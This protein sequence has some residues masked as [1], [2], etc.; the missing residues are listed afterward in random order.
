VKNQLLFVENTYFTCL[1]L[2]KQ[3]LIPLIEHQ[4]KVHI[5]S[6]GSHLDRE[7]LEK[8]GCVCHEIPHLQANPITLFRYV[9][10]L[11][12]LSKSLNP[13][14]VLSFTIRPNVACSLIGSWTKIPTITNTAGIGPLFESNILM[15]RLIRKFLLRSYNANRHNFFENIDDRNLFLNIGIDELKTSILPGGGVD[16]DYFYPI[17]YQDKKPFV[18][19]FITRII[20][21]KGV[22]EFIEGIKLFKNKYPKV[23]VKFQLMG[24]FWDKALSSNQ[25]SETQVQNWIE[26]GLIEYLG[27]QYDIRPYLAEADSLILPSYREGCSNVIMQSLSMQIPVI[28]SNVTGCNQLVSHEEHGY[29]FQARDAAAVAL[30][31]EK[32]IQTPYEIRKKMGLNGRIKMIQAYSRNFVVDAYL[33]QL[34]QLEHL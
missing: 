19:L 8:L 27:V 23:S 10:A 15:Y 26:E 6:S 14:V 12:R 17:D 9:L 18:F 30:A 31:I 24:P 32:M 13:L 4:Y 1:S 5:A 2:R 21:D 33:A 3:L 7:E 34:K 11:Y 20:K 28:C 16:T 22:M 29:L 25:I